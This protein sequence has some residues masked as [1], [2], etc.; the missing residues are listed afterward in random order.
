MDFINEEFS[1]EKQNNYI[2]NIVDNC[3][4]FLDKYEKQF[5]PKN[6]KIQKK[7]SENTNDL[8][9]INIINTNNKIN[10]KNTKNINYKKNTKN[11]K[12]INYKKNTK[13]INYKK[14]TKNTKNIN[15]KKNTK[16]SSNNSKELLKEENR[17]LINA[18]YS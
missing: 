5:F 2:N 18:N 8:D 1:Y 14:N 4:K 16:F 10:T 12:N 6:I 15:Y 3:N 11:T 13:N 9:K 7:N 17:I